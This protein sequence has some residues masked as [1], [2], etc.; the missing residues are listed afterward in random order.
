MQI[1]FPI[2]KVINSSTISFTKDWYDLQPMR[3]K[4][5]IIR[6]IFDNFDNISLTTNYTF[7][8]ENRSFR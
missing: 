2:D 4:Y 5:L 1:E 3:D 6:F 8:K 7:E